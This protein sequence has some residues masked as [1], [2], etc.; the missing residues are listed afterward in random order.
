MPVHPGDDAIC[1]HRDERRLRLRVPY[2]N[3][4]VAAGGEHVVSRPADGNDR[5]VSLVHASLQLPCLLSRLSVVCHRGGHL[6]RKAPGADDGASVWPP[7]WLAARHRVVRHLRARLLNGERALCRFDVEDAERSV[8]IHHRHELA[9]RVDGDRSHVRDTLERLRAVLLLFVDG[10]DAHAVV[11]V[12]GA[13]DVFFVGRE[14]DAPRGQ[15]ESR[16]VSDEL[17]FL[18]LCVDAEQ[19]D[20]VVRGR[21]RDKFPVFRGVDL[22]DVF[23]V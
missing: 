19:L 17:D 7:R 11:S 20:E 22:K 3:A 15:C 13:H 8:S 9:K 1:P 16:E 10:N 12:A 18:V 6:L 23:F 14:C 4:L 2:G 21:R 5:H